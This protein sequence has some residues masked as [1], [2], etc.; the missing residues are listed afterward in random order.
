MFQGQIEDLKKFTYDA[1][2]VRSSRDTFA[3]TTHEITGYITR[4]YKDLGKF[5][6]AMD[7]DVLAFHELVDP[8]TTP[9]ADPTN[10]VQVE[11]WKGQLQIYNDKKT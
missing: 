9:P 11:V 5:I 6:I 7:P 10:L 4:V 8:M 3:T 2:P 1:H